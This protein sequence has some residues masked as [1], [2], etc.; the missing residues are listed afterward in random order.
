MRLENV[1]LMA[2]STVYNAAYYGGTAEELG[3]RDA[4]SEFLTDL[5]VPESLADA[6]TLPQHGTD[7]DGQSDP[8]ALGVCE[9]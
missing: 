7:V 3:G 1:M 9:T 8:D 5:R 6:W 2:L 4:F